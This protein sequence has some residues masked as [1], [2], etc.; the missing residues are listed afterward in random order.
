[1]THEE[2]AEC[3]ARKPELRMHLAKQMSSR[4]ADRQDAHQIVPK[5][6]SFKILWK[7]EICIN[8]LY[9][10]NIRS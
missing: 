6:R 10:E 8:L 1:M 5:W 4:R 3:G 2:E 7:A 9:Q